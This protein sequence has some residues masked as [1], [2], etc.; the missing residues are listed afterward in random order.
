M[1]VRCAW[2]WNNPRL[3]GQEPGKSNLGRRR[4]FLSREPANQI[5]HR[6]IRL[7]VFFRETWSDV[8]EI[9]LVE[10][11]VYVYGTSEEAFS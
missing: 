1:K 11:C 4:L 8:S 6:L 7:P 2:D 3:L 9:G 5:D 10:L